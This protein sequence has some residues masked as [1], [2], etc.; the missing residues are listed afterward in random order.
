MTVL[1]ACLTGMSKPKNDKKANSL[2]QNEQT[3]EHKIDDQEEPG[4]PCGFSN[5]MNFQIESDS[6]I[7]RRGGFRRTCTQPVDFNAPDEEDGFELLNGAQ[8][9]QSRRKTYIKGK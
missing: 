5:V 8:I 6:E 1:E 7:G 9:S 2:V 4:S 3:Q